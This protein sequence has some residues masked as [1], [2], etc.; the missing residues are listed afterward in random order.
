MAGQ[1]VVLIDSS[2]EP[3]SAARLAQVAAALQTQ[4]DRDFGAAWGAL[5]RVGVA[6]RSHIPPGAW[7]ISIVQVPI[8]G[9]GVH[10]DRDGWPR[11][12]V[13][14]GEGWTISASHVLLEMVADPRGQRLMEGRDDCRSGAR[15]VRYLVE[16][17]DPCRTFHYEIDGI[18]V[19]D[20][21]TPDYY[22]AGAAPG[23]AFDFLRRL[24]RPLEVPRGGCLSW[25]DPDDGRWHLR[26]PDGSGSI[27]GA[28]VD[29]GRNPRADRDGAFLG[30]GDRHDLPAVARAPGAARR[31]GGRRARRGIP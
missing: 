1:D 14:A 17:C 5:A 15:R 19:S 23:T 26:R 28:P 30:E 18:R 16:V 20:F 4:I 10:L 8:E 12:E 9:L 21:V 3:V 6:D 27:D 22:R 2:R 13:R 31:R 24:R 11:A 7:T 25:Q 29:P